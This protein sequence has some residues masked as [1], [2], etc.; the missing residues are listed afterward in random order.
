MSKSSLAAPFL[1]LL[2]ALLWGCFTTRAATLDDLDR[3]SDLI[4]ARVETRD[5]K[6]VRGLIGPGYL[7]PA[8]LRLV[9]LQYGPSS[10]VVRYGGWPLVYTSGRVLRN[11]I[12]GDEV[13]LPLA[14]VNRVL[15]ERYSW[16]LTLLTLPLTLPPGLIDFVVHHARF[17]FDTVDTRFDTYSRPPA[18]VPGP[19]V[20]PP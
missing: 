16:P 12:G 11:E 10:W 14:E 4:P 3:L 18:T 20:P 5:G 2:P 9:P 15:L 1:G 6:E 19:V 7:G 17:G 13:E 8:S